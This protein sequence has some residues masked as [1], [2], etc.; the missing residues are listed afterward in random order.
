MR[1]TAIF[2]ILCLLGAL[3]LSFLCLFA[4]SKQSFL[5]SYDLLTL[6]TS[7]IGSN[8]VS[9]NSPIEPLQDI[10]SALPDAINEEISQRADALASRLG[11]DDFYSVHILNY[12]FGTYTP[13]VLPNATLP[14]SDIKRNITGCSNRTAMFEFSPGEIIEQRLNESGVDVTLD[15]LQ[16]PEDIQTGIDALHAVQA[17]VFILYCIS[18]ALVFVAL[19]AAVFGVVGNG[20]LSACVNV[21]ITAVALLAFG[22]A[23]ALVTA[24]VVKGTDVINQHGEQIGLQ[25]SRG[26]KFLALTWAGAGLVFLA[27]VAWVV[28]VCVGGR[29]KRRS[30]YAAAKTG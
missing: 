26:N 12:C 22:V 10:F 4:G 17:A 18:I 9:E 23:S 13:S 27:L 25:A 14:L 8:L 7:R 3:V 29:R 6:N 30:G 15:D 16:W 5:P 21:L 24:V 20:R 19:V 1:L 11:V 28:E 2:P